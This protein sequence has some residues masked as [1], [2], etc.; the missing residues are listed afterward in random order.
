MDKIKVSIDG[1]PSKLAD[2]KR[3]VIQTKLTNNLGEYLKADDI[4]KGGI[5]GHTLNNLRNSGKIHGTKIHGHWFYSK[6]D[7]LRYLKQ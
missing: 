5:S 1:T 6:A 7:I 3:E 4:T 2:I